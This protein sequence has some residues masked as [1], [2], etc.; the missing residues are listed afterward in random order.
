MLMA[1]AFV[2]DHYK[3]KIHFGQL[4]LRQE[5]RNLVFLSKFQI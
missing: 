1:N 3:I 5:D 4:G 2:T